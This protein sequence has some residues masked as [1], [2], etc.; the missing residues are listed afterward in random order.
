MVVA[1]AMG[2][3]PACARWRDPEYLREKA[4]LRTVPVEVRRRGQSAPR[5]PCAPEYS[6]NSTKSVGGRSA[7]SGPGWFH[8]WM[9]RGGA[10]GLRASRSPPARPWRP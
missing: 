6:G 3:W 7:R 1:G 4:G 9:E 2:H 10:A 8:A 5:G